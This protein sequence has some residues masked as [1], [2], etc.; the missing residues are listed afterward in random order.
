MVDPN[1]LAF[2]QSR[3]ANLQTSLAQD[4]ARRAESKA[5]IAQDEA[6]AARR[7]MLTTSS[8][9]A[10]QTIAN[11][12]RQVEAAKDEAVDKLLLIAEKDRMLTEWR[13][14]HAVLRRM[15]IELA[16]KLGMSEDD[17]RKLFHETAIDVAEEDPTFAATDVL[18]KAKAELAS[19][20]G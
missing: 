20:A 19:S 6:S 18:S 11:L 15:T 3:S 10:N 16:G 8:P 13:H 17:R 5:R 12:R 4:D 7:Q 14:S 9:L 1:T 2:E